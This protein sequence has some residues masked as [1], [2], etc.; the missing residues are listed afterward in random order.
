MSGCAV[1][2]HDLYQESLEDYNSSVAAVRTSLAAMKVPVEDWPE[3]IR[4]E[5]E[6][7]MPLPAS[8]VSL[9][10]FQEMERA[11][12]ARREAQAQS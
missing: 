11:L 7:Q 5:S 9:N 6:R 8:A 10:A 12:K 4:P 1:C 2:V 3:S